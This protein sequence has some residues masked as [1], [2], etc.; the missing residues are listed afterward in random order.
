M[1]TDAIP[2]WALER[3]KTI[4]EAHHRKWEAGHDA[5]EQCQ[6]CLSLA[7]LL[8]RALAAQYERGAKEAYRLGATEARQRPYTWVDDLCSEYAYKLL[9]ARSLPL[10]AKE[11]DR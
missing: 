11:G 9:H 7:D 5:Q 3:A 2:G 10:T 8:A 1:T 6:Y 4:L